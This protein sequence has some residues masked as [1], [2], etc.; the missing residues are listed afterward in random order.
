MN[1]IEIK[2]LN[3]NYKD[4]ALENVNLTLPEGCILGLI[5]ENGAGKSTLIKAILSMIKYEGEITVLGA[6]GEKELLNIKDDLGVVFDS[7]Y[8]P[9]AMTA[10]N[11]NSVMKKTYK[12][13][14]EEEFFAFIKKFSLP[15][16]KAFKEFSRGM[17]MKLSIAAALS[18]KAKLLIL[19]EPTGGLDPIM[20]DEIIDI[21]YDYTRDEKNSI[22]ISSHIVSDLE[23]LCDYVA[24]IHN[25]K[26]ILQD[27]KD[28]V[29]ERYGFLNCTREEFDALDKSAVVGSR[30]TSYSA[31]ALIDRA[32]APEIKTDNATLE[33]IIVFTVKGAK[34]R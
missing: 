16:N 3:K 5:G 24:F 25:G 11:V 7:A 2:N 31:E 10:E 15:E 30:I 32:K 29:K 12:N 17:K 33:E 20:R 34:E 4:F 19:D 13:W 14:D 6:K 9:D 21:L 28:R 22:L 23:K 26:I 18:H 27:E 1:A 8:F